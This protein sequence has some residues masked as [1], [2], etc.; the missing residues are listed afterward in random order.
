MI[1]FLQVQLFFQIE[2][3]NLEQLLVYIASDDK[4]QPNNLKTEH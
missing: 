4:F 1:F 3:K 2:P